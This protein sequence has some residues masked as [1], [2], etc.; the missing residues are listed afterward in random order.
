MTLKEKMF[1]YLRENPKASYKELEE[2]A[3]IPYDV[4]K[5]YMCRAKQK[6]EIKELEDGGY[7]V[8]KEP[9][10]EKS[11]YKK[12]VITEMIDIF[13]EDFRTVSPN[14]RVDIGKRITMLLEKL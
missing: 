14:E 5:T 10:V 1:E 6:G 13:M 11:S 8:I 4:A 9:P 3:G 7:E 2:N 12:E